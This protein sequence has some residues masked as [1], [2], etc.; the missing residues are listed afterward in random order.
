MTSRTF[1]RWTTLAALFVLISQILPL[2][3]PARAAAAPEALLQPTPLVLKDGRIANVSIHLLPFDTGQGELGRDVAARLADLVA[4]V[5]TDC[6]LTAQVIGHVSSREVADNET[7]AAHRLARSR[8]DAV[9]ASLIG[10]GLPA[11]AIASVW[12]WQFL[13]REPRATLW[14]FRL[15]QGEDC[16]G[17][18]LDGDASA[19]VAANEPEQ[20]PSTQVAPAATAPVGEQPAEASPAAEAAPAAAVAAAPAAP[21]PAPQAEADQAAAGA[22]LA[23]VVGSAVAA[24]AMPKTEVTAKAAE[25]RPGKDAAPQLEATDAQAATAAPAPRPVAAS[26]DGRDGPQAPEEVVRAGPVPDA[27]P[28]VT[29]PLPAMSPAQPAERRAASSGDRS[30]ERTI[31]AVEPMPA[32]PGKAAQR[33]GTDAAAPQQSARQEDPE[34]QG[35]VEGGQ[36]SV[37]ITFATNSSYFP[38]GTER[39]LSSLLGDTASG[40]SYRIQVEVG[41]SGSDTVVGA[42]TPEEAR[43]YNRWLAER[44]LDRVREWLEENVKDRQLEIEPAFQANDSSRRVVVRVAPI[45]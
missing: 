8:A 13:V 1:A 21:A 30:T 41:V 2:S 34:R 40:G 9:Q 36:D 16:E 19:L 37:V 44:R 42:T 39:R 38:P 18:P 4:T 6:F 45:S 23:G 27:V 32:A 35:K 15:I 31:A 20:T 28:T 14:V 5:A 43:R 10:G 26:S 29:R 33:A 3:W 25:A 22:E 17:V 11:K 24:E 7:L 12:D